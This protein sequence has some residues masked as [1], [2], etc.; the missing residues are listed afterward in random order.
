MTANGPPIPAEDEPALREGV[1]LPWGQFS[2]ESSRWIKA[3]PKGTASEQAPC[4]DET[5]PP[6]GEQSGPW[7]L[8]GDRGGLEHPEQGKPTSFRYS[9][10]TKLVS[11]GGCHK[12]PERAEHRR[13]PASQPEPSSSAT[14]SSSC[15]SPSF[16]SQEPPPGCLFPVSS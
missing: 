4:P 5:H 11:L 14:S 3:A 15:G 6:H 16:G 2:P 10:L 12:L 9:P 13:L 8:G 1:G 7:R